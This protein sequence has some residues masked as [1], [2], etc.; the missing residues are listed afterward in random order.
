MTK[1]STEQLLYLFYVFA[2]SDGDS[3]T[4]GNIKKSLPKEFQKNAD[5]I[6]QELC[7]QDL[8]ESPKRRR[9]SLTTQGKS[10][11]VENLQTTDYQFKTSKGYK[12]VNALLE[13]LKLAASENK[14]TSETIEKMDFETFL[15]NFR[16]LYFEERKRQEKHGLA[17][18]RS[19]D[20]CQQFMEKHSILQKTL[21]Q[22]FER[23]KSEGQVFAVIEKD[24]EIIQWS[25]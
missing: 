16:E 24:E 13:C 7:Q 3:I 20:I 21:N 12:V 17:V 6:C 19:Q 9:V 11:L 25:E 22:Y 18:I 1:L 4:L 15:E 10:V 2:Y 23:L 5:P 14:A 8:L